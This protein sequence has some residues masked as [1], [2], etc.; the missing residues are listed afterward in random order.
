M[1]ICSCNRKSLW[2]VN[3]T[4]ILQCHHPPPTFYAK[5]ALHRFPLLSHIYSAFLPLAAATQLYINQYLRVQH[6]NVNLSSTL[7]VD[8]CHPDDGEN[9]EVGYSSIGPRNAV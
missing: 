3:N 5:V 1:G 8:D 2:A 4:T 7:R 9:A 6:E